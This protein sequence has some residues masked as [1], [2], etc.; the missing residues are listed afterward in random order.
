MSISLA[1]IITWVIV[2][3]LAGSLA[4]LVIKRE[5]R[6]FGL[7]ANLGL[8]LAGALIGGVLFRLLNL[9]PGLESIAISMRDVLA[10]LFGSLLVVLSL[11]LW[12]HFKP[13]P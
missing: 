12:E 3:L 8:G 11:W 9:F 5:R 4:G 1:Q 2:G 13:S 6:G 10:A 7:L